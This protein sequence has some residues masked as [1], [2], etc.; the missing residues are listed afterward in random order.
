VGNYTSNFHTNSNNIPEL[1]FLGSLA[2][3]CLGLAACQNICVELMA[4]F[5]QLINLRAFY[6]KLQTIKIFHYHS[7]AII[8][9]FPGCLPI[10]W[11][12][13]KIPILL[14]DLILGA[15]LVQRNLIRRCRKLGMVISKLGIPTL[16]M[17][18]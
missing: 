4:K 16:L 6:E 3:I 1:F 9:L 13:P 12:M 17:D 8:W 14:R 2:P 7:D 11:L 5:V 10:C 15:L 18:C